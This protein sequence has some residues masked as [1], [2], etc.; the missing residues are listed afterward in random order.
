MISSSRNVGEEGS[1]IMITFNRSCLIRDDVFDR[2]IRAPVRPEVDIVDRC[3]AGCIK[4]DT[5]FEWLTI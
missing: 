2:G 1:F 4:V 5:S 3:L